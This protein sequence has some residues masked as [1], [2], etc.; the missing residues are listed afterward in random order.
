MAGWA[1]ESVGACR[2]KMIVYCENHSKHV[3]TMCGQ[4]AELF[5]STALGIVK[6]DGAL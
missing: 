1:P 4:N 2:A 5:N 6:S 3:N